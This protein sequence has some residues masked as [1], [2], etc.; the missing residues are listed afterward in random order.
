MGGRI[1]GLRLTNE[2]TQQRLAERSGVSERLIREMEKGRKSNPT[3][4]TLRGLA[5]AFGCTI[6]FIAGRSAE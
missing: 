6:D 1:A 5:D 2:W 4:S 3:L